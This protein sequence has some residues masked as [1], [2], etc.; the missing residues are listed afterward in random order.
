MA[1]SSLDLRPLT[2]L[3]NLVGVQIGSLQM[4]EG[5]QTVEESARPDGTDADQR[6]AMKLVEDDREMS[7][8][9]PGAVA[10]AEE[11]AGSPVGEGDSGGGGREGAESAPRLD[12]ERPEDS[13]PEDVPQSAPIPLDPPESLPEAL[14]S[15]E[16]PSAS[17]AEQSNVENTEQVTG[18][19]AETSRAWTVS[20][21]EQEQE[22]S[23]TESEMLVVQ[24]PE[25][26]EGGGD[27]S[28]SSGGGE[29]SVSGTAGA[30]PEEQFSWDS[31]HCV[32]C[33]SSALDQEPKL[34]PCLHS[35][36]N[37][38][39]THEAAEPEMNKDEDI[40]ASKC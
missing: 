28:A 20:S 17:E 32:F 16:E 9:S 21:K 15:P 11:G 14:P 5:G 8:V 40:V 36:C 13:P 33:D 23:P 35:A 7:S 37:K 26:M 1:E 3:E 34:L 10:E 6:N 31:V 24:E 22:P 4:G 18:S 19:E 2:A 29:G 30:G 12:S 38:C 25:A 39:L 27:S